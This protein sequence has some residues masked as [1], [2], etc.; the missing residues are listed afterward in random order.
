MPTNLE[1]PHGEAVAYSACCF[2]IE[3]MDDLLTLYGKGFNAIRQQK[4]LPDNLLAAIADAKLVESSCQRQQEAKT[5]ALQ[6]VEK[7]KSLYPTDGATASQM[8]AQPPTQKQC[9]P[10]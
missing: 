10:K 9:P 2:H 6:E 7:L 5:W 8:L 1:K 3:A 4:P